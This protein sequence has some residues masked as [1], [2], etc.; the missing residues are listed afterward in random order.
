MKRALKPGGQ[1]IMLD[2]HRKELPV[3]PPLE[4]KIDRDELVRQIEGAGL[5]LQQEHTFLPYQYFLV[6]VVQAR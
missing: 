6:F 5:R 1:V 3:G 4:E 2:Y